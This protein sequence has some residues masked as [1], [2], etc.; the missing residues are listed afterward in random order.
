MRD[1]VTVTT[2][3]S[4]SAPSRR[5]WT[6]P[7]LKDL[8]K[9]TDLTLASA[10]GGGGGTGG[11]GSTVFGILLALLTL[12]GCSAER[13]TG[14]SD[15][16]PAPIKMQAVTCQAT[17]ATGK[18]TCAAPQSA[19]GREI[20]G[21]QG[22]YVVLR[23]SNITSGA[24]L[25]T[26]DV[27]VQNLTAQPLG[28]DD[29]ISTNGIFVFFQSGPVVT[30]GTGAV[31]VANAD[32][33]GNFTSPGQSYFKYNTILG[34]LEESA[35]ATWEWSYDPT[36]TDFAFTVL[37]AADVPEQ[38]GM[39]RW[40]P[41]QALED[42]TINFKGMAANG[43]NDVI[44]MGTGAHYLRRT[45]AGWSRHTQTLPVELGTVTAAGAGKFFGVGGDGSQAIAARFNGSL[46]STIGSW[47]D[48]ELIAVYAP[49]ATEVIVGGYDYNASAAFLANFDGEDWQVTHLP[50]SA[51]VSVIG[52]TAAN[53]AWAVNAAGDIYHWGGLGWTLQHTSTATSAGIRSIHMLGASSFAFGGRVYR[54]AGYDE[55]FVARYDG[56]SVDTILVGGKGEVMGVFPAGGGHLLAQVY[57]EAGFFSQFTLLREWNGSTWTTIDSVAGGYVPFTPLGGSEYLVSVEGGILSWDAGSWDTEYG[58]PFTSAEY[59]AIATTGNFV[60]VATEAGEVLTYDGATWASA[61]VSGDRLEA[62]WAFSSTNVYAAGPE[63]MFHFNGTAWTLL[64]LSEV[65]TDIVKMWGSGSTLFAA[66]S[67]TVF[68][69]NGGVWTP[70]GGV[71]GGQYFRDIWGTGPNDVYFVGYPYGLTYFNGTTWAD[72]PLAP[73]APGD[74]SFQLTGVGGTALNDVWIGTDYGVVFHYNGVTSTEYAAPDISTVGGILANGSGQTLICGDGVYLGTTSGIRRIS[75]PGVRCDVG[76][77]RTANGNLWALGARSLH[78]ATR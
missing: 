2:P 71:G 13:G 26:A 8:P 49:S 60:Y 27:T 38:G 72:S 54:G 32:G 66:K 50:G 29:G 40:S 63:G 7:L 42:V 18:V 47:T 19:G 28:T 17:I 34:G 5:V 33:T 37:V 3:P 68:V 57:G 61:G 43:P 58:Q 23:S 73:R 25:F 65:G 78:V 1:A 10:I 59:N 75:H 22:Q 67:D 31:S 48:V 41:V 11:G 70:H 46:W 44:A 39:L 45:A 36:V 14:P 77:V 52:G 15:A 56:V 53:N 9:L 30:G 69:L 64:P 16:L 21:G 4:E 35:P 55:S 24:G 74:S 20:F 76:L 51:E 62:L 6:S 12:A